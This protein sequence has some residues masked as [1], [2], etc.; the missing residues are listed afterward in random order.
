[1]PSPSKELVRGAWSHRRRRRF[2]AG[3]RR[4]R[5]RFCRRRRSSGQAATA[6]DLLVSQGFPWT[7]FPFFSCTRAWPLWTPAGAP[8][9]PCLL[10]S[11]RPG[12]PVSGPR[13][14]PVSALGP[15]DPGTKGFA[16]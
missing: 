5:H 8:P 3:N 11:S 12:L 9:W 1:L 2:S 13:G 7:P 4:C 16:Q 10:R 6:G 14:P 15:F